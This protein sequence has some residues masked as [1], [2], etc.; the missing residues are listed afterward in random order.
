M[1]RASH[2]ILPETRNAKPK[3]MIL[4]YYTLLALTAEWSR[5]LP[6]C[7]VGDV[8]SQSRD[9]LTLA[10]ATPDTS[11]MIKAAT[12]P[13]LQYLFRTKGYNKAKRNVAQLF[14]AALDHKILDV[15]LADRDRVIFIDL[16]HGLRIQLMLF[17]PRAN[18]LL[19]DVEATIVDAF[20]QREKLVGKPAP[21][22]HP[23]PHVTSLADLKTRWRTDRKSTS[24]AIT[25]AFPF[26]N[27]ELTQELIH[28]TGALPEKPADCSDEDLLLVLD[29][30]V[31]L[32]KSITKAA[33][34]IYWK[35]DCAVKFALTDVH[36]EDE[37]R[38]EKF[39]SIDKAVSIYVRRLLR[40]QGFDRVFNPLEKALKT[41]KEGF[42]KR[43][44][45]MLASLSEESRADKYERWGHL[46]MAAQAEVPKQV[47]EIELPD[48]FTENQSV[49]IPLDP[50]LT[51][52]DNAQRYYAKAR[53][54]RQAR[55]H[56]EERLEKTEQLAQEANALLEALYQ[57]KTKS[58]V[59]KFQKAEARRL[60]QF[61]GHQSNS[62]PQVPFRRYDLGAGYEVWVGK[63]AKQND[64][65]TFQHARK[66]DFWLHARGVP[67]SHAVL[68]R[69]GRSSQPSS[70]VQEAAA[71]IAAYHSKARGSAL[72]PVIITERKYVRKPKG[73]QVGT[74]IVEKERVLLVEP[75]IPSA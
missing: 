52:V 2:F 46:L 53:N 73:A 32:E 63:N 22:T 51:T 13:P 68:R 37:L 24:K 36:V 17:G 55:L 19:V 26:M 50:A 75:R 25:A 70:Q 31:A 27:A 40:Q 34:R 65:L 69:P 48:L 28:R 64:A 71:G 72:V 74:V 18:V 66:F 9:E 38:E 62:Q 61:L 21:T 4:N 54:T 45:Q 14:P 42:E 11:W 29:T 49:R 57:Q 67:G 23:A 15:R 12:R 39:E 47:D 20:Q 56:A 33:P 5:D 58:D 6:G 44:D 8:Y 59:E 30:V 41:A 10:V 7:I 3:S 1:F 16:E 43:L 60:A 35:E